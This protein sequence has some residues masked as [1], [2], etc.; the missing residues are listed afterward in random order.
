MNEIKLSKK[1]L[2]AFVLCFSFI[3]LE[4]VQ[5]IIGTAGYGIL[6]IITGLII[7][8]R[9]VKIIYK[10]RQFIIWMF[11]LLWMIICTLINR[12][13]PIYPIYYVGKVAF[14]FLINDWY[15]RKGS[16]RLLKV[17]RKFLEVVVVITLIQQIVAP[18][19]FGYTISMNTR[20]FFTSDNFLGYYYTAYIAVSII[21]DFVEYKKPQKKTYIM[22]GMCFASIIRAWSVKSVI[23]IWLIIMYI[24]FIYRKKISKLF[25][26]RFLAISFVLI[27]FG[28]VIFNVQ[29]NF[30]G[31][32]S[33]Y[34]NKDATVSVRY[35]LWTQAISNIKAKPVFGYGIREGQRLML[36]ETV[37]GNAR[38]SH[39]I[40]LEL[41]L[42]G[43]FIGITIYLISIVAAF[44]NK[45]E[46]IEGKNKYEY[47]FLLFVIFMFF[48]M[49]LASG[50][51]YYP[52][53]YMP[54]ILINNLDK[55]VNIKLMKERYYVSQENMYCY[56]L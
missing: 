19:I 7:F 56:K 45:K 14:W 32:F 23:G 52:Y 9:A 13:N 43:G 42:E 20:T 29:D 2:E 31:F 48:L 46:S 22:T 16:L 27:F 35:Y 12:Q 21:L 18:G 34:F 26:L 49:E 25:G 11:L 55:I 37:A 47:L 30:I 51:I 6:L 38:S 28:V 8:L 53:Y 40:I 3:P 39:N 41:I 4:A 36:Q 44:M 33:K 50:S 15:L 54:I 10:S 5:L 17:S 24:L 1:N